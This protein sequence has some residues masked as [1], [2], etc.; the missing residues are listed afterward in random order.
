MHI[1]MFLEGF[2]LLSETFILHQITG[3]LELGHDIDIYA[4]WRPPSE[5]S[6]HRE[7]ENFNLLSRTT[8]L[9]TPAESAC[10]EMPVWPIT[11]KTWLPGADTPMSN[12]GRVARALPMLLRGFVNAPRMIVQTL[13][14]S[15]YGYQA[16]SL[17]AAYRLVNLC[18]VRSF[19]DVIHAHFGPVGARFRFARELWRAPMVVTFHGY[20]FSVWPRENGQNAYSRLFESM[21]AATV[22]CGHAAQRVA[23]LGCPMAKIRKLNVGIDLRNFK[24]QPRFP[25]RE[26]PIRILTV[27][28]LVHKKGID[29][30]IRALAKVRAIY[31]HIRHDVIGDGMLREQLEHLVSELGLNEV[32]TLH[33][34]QNGSYVRKMMAA[35]HIFALTSV[36]APDGDQEGTPVSL[37]EAQATGMPVLSTNHSGIPEV[38]LDGKSGLLA[39]EGMV[40]SIADKLKQLIRDADRWPEMGR[41]GRA[42]IEQEY[43][44]NILNVR[45][46]ELYNDLMSGYAMHRRRVA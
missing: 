16:A 4:Q 1:A 10:W 8:Y 12:A 9:D 26:E 29:L 22:N 39:Q 18:R 32:V 15:E 14:P 36:T 37:M 25:S 34:A 23:E 33:G 20:D 31:P 11:G 28:R 7:V 5:Q 13:R 44:L 35:S 30:M 38:V 24:Y 21:D 19:Y 27:G 42:R 45:T 41:H 46:V 2:P 17:S 6:I 40:D 43:D 3:L